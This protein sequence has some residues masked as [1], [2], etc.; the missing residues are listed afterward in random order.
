MTSTASHAASQ[1]ARDAGPGAALQRGYA[2]QDA[3]RCALEAAGARVIGWKLGAN[4]MAARARLGLRESV[5]GFLTDRTLQP[6]SV[7]VSLAGCTL[8]GLEPEIAI[9]VGADLPGDAGPEQCAAAIAGMSLAAELIDVAG[10]YDDVA[11]LVGGNIFHHSVRFDAAVVP[12]QAATWKTTTISVT[13]NGMA[14]PPFTVDIMTGALPAVLG[15]VA[16]VLAA[17]GLRL[18]AGQ[19]VISGIAIPIPVWVVPG[20]RVAIACSA[21]GSLDMT[22]TA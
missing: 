15:H 4:E 1:A 2:A 10:R 8:P 7:P 13:R 18:R 5:V 20:D 9:H 11:A 14:A 3:A 22:F 16:A 17:R 21:G 19:T 6:P 12:W